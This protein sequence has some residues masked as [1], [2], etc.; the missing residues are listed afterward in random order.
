MTAI[1]IG[2]KPRAA[3]VDA[4]NSRA[5]WLYEH[6]GKRVIGVVELLHVSRTEPAPDEEKDRA[7]ELAI[8]ALEFATIEQED[9]LRKALRAL[10]MIRTATGT[11]DPD[12]EVEMSQRVL[13]YTN[14]DLS[15]REAV[16]LTAGIRVWADRAWAAQRTE[17]ASPIELQHELEAISAGLRALLQGTPEDLR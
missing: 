11:L 5:D 1:K 12:G 9:T 4:L 2:G 14:N 10:F 3:A 7:V 6:P 8:G 16:R 13:D 15:L 17:N